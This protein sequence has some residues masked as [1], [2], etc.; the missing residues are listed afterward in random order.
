MLQRPPVGE[1]DQNGVGHQIRYWHP[2]A[3]QRPTTKDLKITTKV[4]IT[5]KAVVTAKEVV[6]NQVD[7][8]E[9]PLEV[10]GTENEVAEHGSTPTP[11]TEVQK[12]RF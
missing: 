8:E 1:N 12:Y 9:G 11:E 5:P 3:G 7:E 4:V 2:Q 10:S 6:I